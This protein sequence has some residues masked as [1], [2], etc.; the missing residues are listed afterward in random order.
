[1]SRLLFA[2]DPFDAGTIKL[3][4]KALKLRE[5]SD[6]V[7]AGIVLVPEERRK[8]GI[9]VGE[10]VRSNMSLPSLK[11]LSG[12]LGFLRRKQ[13]SEL[14][15]EQVEKLGVKTPSIQQ[16]VGYL[17]G[18]NQQKVAIG[19]W[20]STQADVFL[21]DEPTKGVDIGAKSDIFHIIG[22]LAQQGKG[23]VYFSCEFAEIMGI[24]DR[25]YVMCDGQLVKEFARG[26]V[27]QDQ[28]LYYASAGQ[29]VV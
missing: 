14:A 5:P 9:L 1:L 28:L 24:A 21:F 22:Q 15:R 13:E 20:L 6:A 3:R 12:A 7:E 17:S 19:K 18:G 2:A 11:R 4:G 16:L 26:E 25:I 23:I 10:S 8:Q 27:T 29:E